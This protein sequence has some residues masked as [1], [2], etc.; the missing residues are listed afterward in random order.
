MIL[1]R[2][3]F[4]ASSFA[5]VSASFIAHAAEPWSD[6]R[7]AVTNG[8][9]LWFDVSRQNAARGSL[10]FAP[11]QSWRDAPDYFF[12][13]SGNRRHLAQPILEA[14]P[15]F[16]QDFD[17]AKL[18]FDGTND[19]LAATSLG[20]AFADTTLFVVGAPATNGDFRA[21]VAFNAAGQNDY[22][23]GVNFDFGSAISSTLARINA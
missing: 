20:T 16:R 6:A 22:T 5:V 11:L 18:S 7:L 14:R 13:G 3:A 10:S 2:F 21:L 19:F 4:L 15:R 8:L 9:A 23:S 12:D 1:S 17:G